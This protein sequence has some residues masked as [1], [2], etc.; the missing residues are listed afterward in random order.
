MANKYHI[1]Y[2]KNPEDGKSYK[3]RLQA[4]MNKGKIGGLT[5][6]GEQRLNQALRKYQ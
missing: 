3:E 5:S 4:E 6:W 2:K 1:R